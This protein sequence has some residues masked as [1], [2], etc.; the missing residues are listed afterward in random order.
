M[1]PPSEFQPARLVRRRQA[2]RLS[3]RAAGELAGIPW[4]TWHHYERGD[5]TPRFEAIL[6][7]WEPD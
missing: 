6:A 5:R 3:L 2:K 4:T 1:P 7:R